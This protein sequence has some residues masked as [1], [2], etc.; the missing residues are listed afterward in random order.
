MSSEVLNLFERLEETTRLSAGCKTTLVDALEEKR[1]AKGDVLLKKGDYCDQMT[2]VNSGMLRGYI[3][4]KKEEM[5]ARFCLPGHLCLVPHSFFNHVPSE[6]TLAALDDS[7]VHQMDKPMMEQ[8]G[9]DYPEFRTLVERLIWKDYL[10]AEAHLW[11]LRVKTSHERFLELK[12]LFP[13]PERHA[14]SYYASYIGLTQE[15]IRRFQKEDRK[16]R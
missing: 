14:A 4:Y 9:E 16:K 11:L 2:F 10:M 5:T 1:L 7:I 6:E 13:H 12:E 8:I 15:K 3:V